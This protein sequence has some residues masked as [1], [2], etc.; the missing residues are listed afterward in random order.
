MASSAVQLILQ[1]MYFLIKSD[2]FATYEPKIVHSRA[3]SFSSSLFSRLDS[4]CV[5]K[6]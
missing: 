1:Y 3:R 6:H 2:S 5:Y 4:V